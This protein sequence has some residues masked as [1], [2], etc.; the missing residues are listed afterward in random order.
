M[1]TTRRCHKKLAGQNQFT[2][3]SFVLTFVCSYF[4]SQQN[5]FIKYFSFA[6]GSVNTLKVCCAQFNVRVN[7][8]GLEIKVEKKG[9]FT[10]EIMLCWVCTSQKQ[11]WKQWHTSCQQ[12][13]CDFVCQ[14]SVS[15]FR[16]VWAGRWVLGDRE[17]SAR[18]GRGGRVKGA[19][20]QLMPGVSHLPPRQPVCHPLYHNLC[21]Q[22]KGTRPGPGPWKLTPE[23]RRESCR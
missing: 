13:S 23:T 11:T 6:Q 17:K 3:K 2:W 7:T 20:A 14:M 4:L 16:R 18:G 5:K 1:Q 15:S 8:A 12:T 22:N 10:I 21:W 9:S 19:G